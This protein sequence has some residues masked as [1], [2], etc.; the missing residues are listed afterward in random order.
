MLSLNKSIKKAVVGLIKP[1]SDR[2]RDVILRRFGLK[3]GRPETL[4][5]I[6]QGYGITRER[7][8]Q[9]EEYAIKN[10]RCFS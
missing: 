5:S 2:N 7:V 6:G 10:L 4:E 9:I 1:L 8:R 3:N